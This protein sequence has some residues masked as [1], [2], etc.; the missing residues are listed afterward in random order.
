ME[1]KQAKTVGL[2]PWKPITVRLLRDQLETFG[3]EN[4]MVTL[5]PVSGGYRF[6]AHPAYSFKESRAICSE[7]SRR[8]RVFKNI[9]SALNLAR[10]YGFTAVAVELVT[11]T[12]LTPIE[13]QTS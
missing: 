4:W 3:K 6:H 1:L 9:E 5:V 12:E 2:K 8:V 10:S 11:L 7:K 13:T